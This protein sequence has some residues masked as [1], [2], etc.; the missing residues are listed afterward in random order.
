MAYTIIRKARKTTFDVETGFI[1]A[2]GF[3][4]DPVSRH[5]DYTIRRYTIVIPF[6]VLSIKIKKSKK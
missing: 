3:A 2:I 1:I 6:V 5:A 4:A